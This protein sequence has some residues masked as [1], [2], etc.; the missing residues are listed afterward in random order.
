[1]SY[2]T[3][4]LRS[5]G[6]GFRVGDP[7][8][9]EESMRLFHLRM[10]GFGYPGQQLCPVIAGSTLIPA[11]VV[12]DVDAVNQYGVRLYPHAIITPSSGVLGD[13]SYVPEVR[14][15][16]DLTDQAF[17]RYSYLLKASD[18]RLAKDLKDRTAL[19]VF[20]L[21]E[22]SPG[23]M[24]SLRTYP[25][26]DLAIANK[27]HNGMMKL[28]LASHSHGNVSARMSYFRE[29]V[30]TTQGKL[31]L[32]A[33]IGLLRTRASHTAVA[34][35]EAATP[36]F[37]RTDRLVRAIFLLG[38]DRAVYE[39]PVQ[40]F[41]EDKP[42]ASSADAMVAMMTYFRDVVNTRP[43]TSVMHIPRAMVAEESLVHAAVVPPPARSPK[44]VVGMHGKWQFKLHSQYCE[45][46][47][48]NGY[49]NDTHTKAD[50]RFYARHLQR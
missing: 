37:I 9:F 40:R 48:G 3:T 30:T 45:F 1:M 43:V 5:D 32:D 39:R 18:E 42:D 26:W 11:P 4:L 12:P 7:I 50:C 41:N 15:G 16:P 2:L 27:D 44:A 22:I 25:T 36:G 33:F 38:L 47:F 24:D 46:C 14:G 21:S 49:K 34:F 20:I 6:P 19:V 31:S 28:I 8:F 17:H 13:S 29:F 35:E 23:S 10:V